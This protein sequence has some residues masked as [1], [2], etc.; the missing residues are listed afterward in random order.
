MVRAYSMKVRKFP[1]LQS[2]CLYITLYNSTHR[3][4]R[5]GDR[6]EAWYTTICAISAYHN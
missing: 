5:G 1:K 2:R 3:G 4:R 6:M